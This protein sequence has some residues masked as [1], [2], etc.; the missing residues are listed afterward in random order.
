MIIEEV[1]WMLPSKTCKRRKCFVEC[2]YPGRSAHEFRADGTL[3]GSDPNSTSPI[4][5][6]RVW[7]GC[8]TELHYGCP[9]RF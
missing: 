4:V 8:N 5:K 2:L 6:R 3:A 7:K 1:I 9:D